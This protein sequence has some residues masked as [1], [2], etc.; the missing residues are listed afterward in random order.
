MTRLIKAHASAL[1][2]MAAVL[3][4][5]CE[6]KWEK[7][8]DDELAAK[9]AECMALTDPSSAMIQVCKNYERE[10]SRRRDNGIYVC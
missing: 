2:V 10:C 1:L 7:M 3:L 8:P 4:T 5:A 6:N 9:S